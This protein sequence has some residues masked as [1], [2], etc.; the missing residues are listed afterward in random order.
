[1]PKGTIIPSTIQK[2][3]ERCLNETIDILVERGL[4]TSG[5]TLAKV[6]PQLTSGIRAAGIKNPTLHR[7]YAAIY[8]AFRCRRSLLLINL[9][10]QV[11][12]EELPWVAAIDQF[13]DENISTQDIARQT[14]EE[15]TILA[16]TSFPHVI[17]P[18]K[19]LQ[20]LR[21]LVKS[22]GMDIPL[23]D[24][25]A[26]DIFMGQFSDKFIESAKRAA[27]LLNGSIYQ[28]YYSID[29]ND[30]LKIPIVAKKIKRKWLWKS[31]GS[32]T[33]KFV[34][35]C[36]SRAGVSLGTWD[37]ATNGMIIEQQQILTTQNLATLILDLNL[38]D[39]LHMQLSEM[40]RQ[41]FIWICD[42]QQVKVDNWHSK[43][44]IIKNTAYAW[45]QMIFFLS[46][47]PNSEV[48]NFLCWADAYL[49]KQKED[50]QNRFRNVL[51]GLELAAEGFSI[52]SASARKTDVGQFLG[53]SK[54]KHWLLG[55]LGN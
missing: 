47:I 46:L 24:E 21:A 8:R 48:G 20:E 2:K 27:K 43:L 42:R 45:R 54:S 40:I 36:A 49:K 7:L 5:E 37:P 51:K 28:T 32:S 30:I 16:I 11:Q 15:I 55:D 34:Q 18:N 22:A 23:V 41:C 35:L 31:D 38:K 50:F 29:Y 25:L 1:M 26:A 33:N 17:I 4:I 3:V 39:S 12:I 52:D 6:L 44:I 13:R 9:E 19:L 14:L 10:K 53:W